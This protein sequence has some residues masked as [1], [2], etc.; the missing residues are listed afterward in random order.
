MEKISHL[1]RK[2]FTV[3]CLIVLLAGFLAILDNDFSSA[4]TIARATVQ[5]QVISQS[6]IK[7]PQTRFDFWFAGLRRQLHLN[8]VRRTAA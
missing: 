3:G 6:E 1:L 8:P 7:A 5:I 4:K 2:K